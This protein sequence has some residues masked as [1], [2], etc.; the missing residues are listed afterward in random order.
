MTLL[1]TNSVQQKIESVSELVQGYQNRKETS[2]T[3]LQVYPG[4]CCR[5]R[6][7]V[8]VTAGSGPITTFVLTTATHT[9]YQHKQCSMVSYHY[10]VVIKTEAISVLGENY[11][12]IIDTSFETHLL[13]QYFCPF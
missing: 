12:K 2:K 6:A 9:G 4:Q 7:N 3:P 11:C 5:S 8:V 10:Q 1:F 13:R